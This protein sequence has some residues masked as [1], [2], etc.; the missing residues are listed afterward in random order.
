MILA[1]KRN[2]ILSTRTQK[3]R[4]VIRSLFHFFSTRMFIDSRV[5]Q[6]RPLS[7]SSSTLSVSK[8]ITS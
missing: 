3:W 7:S 4:Y 5:Q 6:I 1:M 8:S 2:E